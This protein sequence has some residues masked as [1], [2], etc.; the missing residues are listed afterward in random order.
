[1]T[2]VRKGKDPKQR[3]GR[4]RHRQRSTDV[5]KFLEVESGGGPETQD[6]EMVRV[7]ISIL[8]L[9]MLDVSLFCINRILCFWTLRAY[10]YF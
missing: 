2:E 8:S 1:M 7:E 10:R 4:K 3:K 6:E 5:R 9:K